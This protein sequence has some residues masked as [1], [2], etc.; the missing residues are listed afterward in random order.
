MFS[1]PRGLLFEHFL[2]ALGDMGQRIHQS[3]R[4]FCRVDINHYSVHGVRYA[5]ISFMHSAVPYNYDPSVD[6]DLLARFQPG[7]YST[8]GSVRVG[9]G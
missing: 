6:G 3:S 9:C 2:D 5:A 4:L 7:R 1:M 8:L